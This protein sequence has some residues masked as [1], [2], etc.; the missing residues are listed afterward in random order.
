MT[1]ITNKLSAW[2]P[3][4]MSGAAIVVLIVAFIT[5]HGVIVRQ[6]DEGTA[7]HL[8]QLL[9]GGQLPIIAYFIVR[10]SWQNTKQGLIV[11]L[12]QLLAGLMACAPVYYFKL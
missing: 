11:I 5:T 7:A 10:W 6:P 3:I 2:L 4:A 8:W 1:K 12:L 9:M